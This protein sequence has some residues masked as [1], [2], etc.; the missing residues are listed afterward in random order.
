VDA[1]VVAV[2]LDLDAS[3]ASPRTRD[4]ARSVVD[5]FI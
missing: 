2:G 3:P 1:A 4:P 5:L